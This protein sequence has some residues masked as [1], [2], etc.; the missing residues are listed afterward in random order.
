M[1]EDPDDDLGGRAA[2]GD[3]RPEAAPPLDHRAA[4]RADGAAGMTKGLVSFGVVPIADKTCKCGL[5]PRAVWAVNTRSGGPGAVWLCGPHGDALAADGG[6]LQSLTGTCGAGRGAAPCGAPATHIAI[7]G[8]PGRQGVHAISVCS[9]HLPGDGAAG[10]KGEDERPKDIEYWWSGGF[11]GAFALERR[12]RLV[13]P[14]LFGAFRRVLLAMPED[15]F[16]RFMEMSP[17]VVCQPVIHGAAY[18]Y[19]LPVVPGAQSV[20]LYV[21][22]FRPDL[23]KFSDD[24]LAR[25][26][27]HETAHLVLGH[28]AEAGRQAVGDGEVHAEEAADRKAE[29]WG[30]KGAYSREHRRRLARQD[31]EAKEKRQ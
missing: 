15:D 20:R 4:A 3:H 22:Y 18:S 23:E 19:Y 31:K 17:T 2:P 24:K 28:A 30:F 10:M 29:S 1:I 9:E 7:L 8:V 16:E 6:P 21:L 12:G 26:V 13:Q 25:L 5:P 11:P 27:A 14:R